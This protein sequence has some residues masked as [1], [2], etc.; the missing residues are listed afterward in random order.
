MKARPEGWKAVGNRAQ[1]MPYTVEAQASRFWGGAWLCPAL[2]SR[3]IRPTS[4]HHLNIKTRT[5]Q[6]TPH[7]DATFTNDPNQGS[8]SAHYICYWT[9]GSVWRTQPIHEVPKQGNLHGWWLPTLRWYHSFVCN[10]F[11]VRKSFPMESALRSEKKYL[12][13]NPELW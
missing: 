13:L 11:I 1:T 4:L 3:I 5:R 12:R 10:D 7:Q 9:N 8:F 2:C 6:P